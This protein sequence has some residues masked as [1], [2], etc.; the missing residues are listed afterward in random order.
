MSNRGVEEKTGKE[1]ENRGS[2][3]ISM[4][5]SSFCLEMYLKHSC[6]LPVFMLISLSES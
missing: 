6:D 2:V 1:W 5:I 4:V 3:P